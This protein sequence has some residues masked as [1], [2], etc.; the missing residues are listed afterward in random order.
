[1][2]V[3]TCILC[4]GSDFSVLCPA[5][6]SGLH[7]VEET[8]VTRSRVCHCG[9]PVEPRDPDPWEGRM[10]D[11]C[12]DCA[13]C[14]CD[15]SY[16]TCPHATPDRAATWDD[17]RAAWLRANLPGLHVGRSQ[18]HVWHV[19]DARHQEP[20]CY[21]EQQALI[22]E[23]GPLDTTHPQVR[24]CKHCVRKQGDNYGEW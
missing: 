9:R 14:R 7:H 8:H 6:E 24:L 19:L 1:M 16:S 4:G 22:I 5:N 3:G 13:T 11:Y 2:S 20:L 15:T 18:N 23:D 12:E 10:D 17:T 21:V